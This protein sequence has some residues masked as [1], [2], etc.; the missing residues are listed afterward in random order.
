VFLFPNGSKDMIRNAV[1]RI[2][3]LLAIAMGYAAV[4]MDPRSKSNFHLGSKSNFHLGRFLRNAAIIAA[5]IGCATWFWFGYLRDR[6]VAKRF[7][8]VTP[9][10]FR[11]GM[12]SEHVIPRVLDENG[13]QCIIDL[14]EREWQP[15][16]KIAERAAAKERGVEIREYPLV[17]DG[18]GSVDAYVA[19][20]K[21]LIAADVTG[22]KT[23]VHCAGGSYRTGGVIAT[24]RMLRQGWSPEDALDEAR[25][26][27]WNPSDVILPNYLS[28]HIDEIRARL[29]ADGSLPADAPRPVV[30]RR[31]GPAVEIDRETERNS[32]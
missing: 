12:I 4:S 22:R 16:R 21:D 25:R 1:D 11:S 23:L 30:P 8:E 14:T 7:G 27:K 5:V 17:G 9:S 13:I 19:A 26:Y 20:V 6:V 32:K 31:N 10:V 2:T 15:E 24:F 29:I 18:T 3:A 28:D